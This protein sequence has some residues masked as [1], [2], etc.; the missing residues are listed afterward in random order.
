MKVDAARLNVR[1]SALKATILP[2]ANSAI[3][4]LVALIFHGLF[5]RAV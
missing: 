5:M 4:S 3:A 1:S 2:S